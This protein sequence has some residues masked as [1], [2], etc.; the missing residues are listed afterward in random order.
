M[1]YNIDD[2]SIKYNSNFK[3]LFIELPKI[4]TKYSNREVNTFLQYYR[5]IESIK[6]IDKLCDFDSYK[7]IVRIRPDSKF[8]CN[9]TEFQTLIESIVC[10]SEFNEKT[11]YIPKGYDIFDS[12]FVSENRISIE[13]CINDQIC[14]CNPRIFKL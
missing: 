7:G 10:N 12:R 6:Q 2:S 1:N 3:H 8:K 4:D 9:H 13:E 14:I 5:L 11:I